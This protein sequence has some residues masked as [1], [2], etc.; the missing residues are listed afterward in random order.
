[1]V[2]KRGSVP[3]ISFWAWNLKIAFRPE[4][5]A[6]TK[7]VFKTGMWLPTSASVDE[8]MTAVGLAMGIY[9]ALER[10]DQAVGDRVYDS[11]NRIGS[12]DTAGQV[13]NAGFPDAY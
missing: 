6:R 11:E 12:R 9:T 7:L 1:V 3:E 4:H 2:I 13:P 8:V 5:E 10:Q